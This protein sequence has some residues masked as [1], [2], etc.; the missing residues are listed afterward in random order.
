M[1]AR[2]MLDRQLVLA[3]AAVFGEV[4]LDTEISSMK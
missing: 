1:V 3:P 4:E 2:Y